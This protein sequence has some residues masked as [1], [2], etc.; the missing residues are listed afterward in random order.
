MGSCM[1]RP[2]VGIGYIGE[3]WLWIEDIKDFEEAIRDLVREKVAVSAK[4]LVPDPNAPKSA[5][6]PVTYHFRALAS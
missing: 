3:F 1:I 6:D 4:Q 5:W 2:F